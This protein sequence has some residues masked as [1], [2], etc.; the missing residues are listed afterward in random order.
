VLYRRI[1]GCFWSV[2]YAFCM[3][4]SAAQSITTLPAPAVEASVQQASALIAAG[5]LAEAEAPLRAAFALSPHDPATLSL[6][7]QLEGRLGEAKEAAVT[8]QQLILVQPESATAHLNFALAL[9]DDADLPRALREVTISIRLDPNNVRAHLNKARFLV[10]LHR[11]AEA[12]TEFTRAAHLSPDDPEINFFRAQFE[13]E[14]H[15]PEAAVPLLEE[16]VKKQPQNMRAYLLLAHILETLH[17][18]QEAIVAWQKVK[19]LEPSS[20]EATYA[21]AQELRATDPDAAAKMLQ[22]FQQIQA[23]RQRADQA[24]QMGNEAYSRMQRN[25]W[26]GASTT[27]EAAIKICGDCALQADLYQ[28]LGLAECHGGDLD[29]GE[30]ELRVALSL[31]PTDRQTVEALAWVDEQRKLRAPK[32]QP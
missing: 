8:F 19:A 3:H 1:M 7:G 23:A 12:R 13:A 15:H 2:T 18:H 31:N 5:R 16:A 25:D 24:R 27:L 22:D 6:L 9:A 4:H 32:P 17:R 14:E 28:R 11:N 26:S 20:T 10:E 21:L 30:R 29:A